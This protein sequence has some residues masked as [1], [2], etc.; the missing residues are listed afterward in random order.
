MMMMKLFPLSSLII[1]GALA[2]CGSDQ[3]RKPAV[4]VKKLPPCL[5]AYVEYK[6]DFENTPEI[7]DVQLD[8]LLAW[9][10][11]AGLWDFPGKTKL[12]VIYPDDPHSTPKSE[13]RMFMAISVPQNTAVPSKF[14]TMTI[15]GGEYAVGKF[16]ISSEEFGRSWGYMYSE[17]IPSSGYYPA[18]GM[19][20]ENK[21]NDSDTHPARKHI[22]EICIPVIKK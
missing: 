15:P 10:I 9:A 8:K 20:F 5:V 16:E 22:V 18:Q 2:G 12:I 7:Y 19:S 6:G 1:A 21:L 4:S 14:K 3:I 17:F 11:P 13:Q